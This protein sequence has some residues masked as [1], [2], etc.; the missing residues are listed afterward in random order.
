MRGLKERGLNRAFTVSSF[1]VI[2]M[3]SVQSIES[4]L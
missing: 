4:I 1:N 3:S 2:S